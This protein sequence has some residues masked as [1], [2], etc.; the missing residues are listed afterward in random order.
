MS[1]ELTYCAG[2][3][4][5]PALNSAGVRSFFTTRQGGVGTGA[6]ASLNL[7]LHTDDDPA[8]VRANR[9]RLQA[10]LPSKPV[11]LTQ[12]HGAEVW[13]ADTPCDATDVDAMPVNQTHVNQAPQADAAITTTSQRV[14]AI[15]VADCLP[16]VIADPRGR[17]LGVAHAGWRGLAAGVL[18]NTV[19]A[20]RARGAGCGANRGATETGWHAWIGPCIGPRAFEVG[21]A[22]R[23]A[24]AGCAGGTDADTDIDAAFVAR[25][26]QR[27]KWLAD[28]PRLAELRLRHAGVTHIQHAS[29][30]TVAHPDLFFSYRRDGGVT[31]RMA[32]LAWLP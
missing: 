15:L 31:G 10:A 3:P 14:L 29:L 19:A 12:V 18:E 6:Y 26:N 7:G 2:L 1:H 20:M 24:F 25:P 30:C 21:V 5:L 17:V 28:L 23:A 27:D 11:W 8:V 22:V 9:C 32:L 16:V 4:V 13:D